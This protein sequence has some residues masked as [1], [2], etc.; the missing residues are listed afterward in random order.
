[1]DRAKFATNELN[2]N[3]GRTEESSSTS[4]CRDHTQISELNPC[5]EC[6]PDEPVHQLYR[7]MEYPHPTSFARQCLI[8]I[9]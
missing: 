9:Y 1:M 3:Y 7:L 4:L 8:V 6:M 5:I 2:K